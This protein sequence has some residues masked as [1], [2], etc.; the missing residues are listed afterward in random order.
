MSI[1]WIRLYGVFRNN[2]EGSNNQFVV[3][4]ELDTSKSRLACGMFPVEEVA[5]NFS[6]SVGEQ[7]YCY[8]K[9]ENVDCGSFYLSRPESNFGVL[10]AL[11]TC[12]EV[13]LNWQESAFEQEYRN[14]KANDEN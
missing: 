4:A 9:K 5:C 1:Y 10:E 8:G 13:R 7:F 12:S 2:L 3:D 14:I 11:K 6:K